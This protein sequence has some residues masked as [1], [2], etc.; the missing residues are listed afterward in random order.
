MPI[1]T[2]YATINQL[3]VQYRQSRYRNLIEQKDL[4]WMRAQAHS[5]IWQWDTTS[6][7][8]TRMPGQFH[9]GIAP[10]IES[11]NGRLMLISIVRLRNSVADEAWHIILLQEDG[12]WSKRRAGHWVH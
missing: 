3:A 12:I 6:I 10:P 11:R 4:K 8:S 9:Y 1:Q 7:T 2:P 5:P